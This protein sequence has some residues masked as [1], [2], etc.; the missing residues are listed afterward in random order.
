MLIGEFAARA[1]LSQDTVR[2]YVRKGLLAPQSGAKGGRNPYQIFSERDV[3]TAL[4]IRFAQ[5]LGMSLKEVAAIAAELL[6]DGLSAEREIAI[7]DTQ[8]AR[9][10]QKA[11]ELARLLDY[12]HAKR[13]WM[14]RGK[15]GDEPR[16][17]GEDLCLTEIATP[18]VSRAT[19]AA[20]EEIKLPE[21]FRSW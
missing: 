18:A 13:N 11:A 15:P 10:E 5:S 14:A 12:L 1:G 20:T 19:V 3:S 7:I 21:A 6:G 4:M 16:F 8:V 17:S 2:F 9:L